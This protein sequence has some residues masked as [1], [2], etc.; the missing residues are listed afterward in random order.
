MNSEIVN[1]IKNDSWNKTENPFADVNCDGHVDQADIDL[2]EKM[3]KK[4]ECI[5]NYIDGRG[6]VAKAHYPIDGNIG[7]HR[8]YGCDMALAL[9]IWDRLI[10]V[11]E[12]SIAKG[13]VAYP[14]ITS[15]INLGLSSTMEAETVLKSGVEALIFSGA[16]DKNGLSDKLNKS[17]Q[18]IDCIFL[19]VGGP[20]SVNSM[21]IL[22]V[23][24]GCEKRCAEYLAFYD[25]VMGVITNNAEAMKKYT[26]DF[27]NPYN[28]TNT[29]KV[30]IDTETKDGKVM[31]DT[32]WIKLLQLNNVGPKDDSVCVPRSME[33]IIDLNPEYIIISTAD[34]GYVNDITSAQAKFDAAAEIFKGTGAYNEK[35]VIG[36][37]FNSLGSIYGFA[38]LMLLGA[39]M[40]PDVYDVDYGWE[41]LQKWFDDFTMLDLDVH[42]VGGGVFMMH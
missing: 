7:T 24:L 39:Y 21:A 28:P 4:E 30:Y 6:V 31:N 11:D 1:I 14:G 13:E 42:K 9:G 35:K 27:I 18:N 37:S 15:K 8:W 16:T 26:T 5:V 25:E 33:W 41:T 29:E 23:L 22:G 3:I 12:Q 32:A 38:G 34:G 10:A 19:D 17:G 36:M 40:F 20:D 2:L